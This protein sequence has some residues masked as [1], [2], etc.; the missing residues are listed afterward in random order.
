MGAPVDRRPSEF[1]DVVEPADFP[2]VPRD[3][4]AV[5][6]EFARGGLGRILRADDL[7]L[8]RTV[9]IKELLSKDA[10]AQARFIREAKITARLEHPNI[11]PIHEAGHWPD[12]PRFYAMK[13]VLGMTLATRLEEAVTDEERLQLVPHLIGVADAVAYA[14]SQG[15]LHRDLKPSNVMVGRFGE[16]VLIDWGLAKDLNDAESEPPSSDDRM[17]PGVFETSDGIVVGTPPY[18]PPEQAMAKRLDQRADVYSLGAMLYHVLSGHRPYHDTHPREILSRVVREPPVPLEEL[19]YD[20]PPDL[21]AIVNKAMARRPAD[22]YRSAEEMAAELRR[23]TA[24]R[25]VRAHSY[26]SWELLSRF[27]RRN[28]AS[29][30]VALMAAFGLMML[31]WWSYVQIGEERD[32]ARRN[33]KLAQ[34]ELEKFTLEK[35][36]VLLASDPTEALAWLKRLRPRT[37]QAATV[38]AEADDLGV[39]RLVLK[40]HSAVVNQVAITA[41]GRWGASVSDDRTVRLWDLA[42]GKSTALKAHTEK[43]TQ[44]VFSPDGQWLA[45]GSHDRTVRLWSLAERAKTRA[46]DGSSVGKSLDAQRAERA[47]MGRPAWPD[48]SP[49]SKSLDAQRAERA[50]MGRPAWPDGAPRSKSLD[51]QRAERAQMGRPAWP[52]GSPRSKSLDAQRAE[53]AQMGRPAWPDGAPLIGA[54]GPIKAIAFDQQGARVAAACE[55]GRVLVWSVDGTRLHVFPADGTGRYPDLA[56]VPAPDGSPS[57]WLAVGGFGPEVR[58]WSLDRVGLSAPAYRRLLGPTGRTAGLAVS[59]DGRSVA[60]GM[61]DGPVYVW[62]TEP[63]ESEPRVLPGPDDRR[64]RTLAFSPDGARL[65]AAGLDRRVRVWDLQSGQVRLL[66]GHEERVSDLAF[67]PSGAA[68]LSASWDGTVRMWMNLD[69]GGTTAD[70]LVFRGHADAVTGLAIS[71][72]GRHLLSGSWDQTLRLWEVS[73]QRQRVL[74]GHT[75]GVHGLAFGPQGRRLYSGGHDDQVRAWALDTRQSMVLGDHEDHIFRVQVSPDGRWVASSS[76]DRTVRLWNVETGDHRALRG[77]DA[78]VEEIAFSADSRWVVS[79]G[80]DNMAWLWSVPSGD[81]LRLSGHEND[82]TDVAFDPE[83]QRLATSSRDG[84]VRVWRTDGGVEHIFRD[85]T[86][87]VWSVAFSPNGQEVAAASADGR[88]RIWSIDSGAL[89]KTYQDLGEARRARFSPDGAFI[90]VTTSGRNLYLC[91]RAFD[92]C[93]RLVGHAAM[94]HDLTFSPDGH[95]LVTGASDNSVRV[96]DVETNES[97]VYRGHAAPVFDVDVSPDGRWIASGSADADIRVWPLRLPPKPDRL[98]AWLVDR[99]RKTVE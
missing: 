70:A 87:E 6:E 36:R 84:S 19:T 42:K 88:L 62:A 56:F 50:Q 91:R 13:L 99:T 45:T 78:D 79:A 10:R 54:A 90:A 98:R 61:A 11:V 39:A 17:S 20:L 55:D 93:D 52:D 2:V 38:A 3:N 44:V 67:A 32:I 51:A 68:I 82:V 26:S 66:V 57:K 58:L 59:A 9:A 46:T 8:G 85:A 97:R 89:V 15:I 64:W 21:V 43:V 65:A 73:P 74:R 75:V 30:T 40:G 31:G 35:A 41:D 24:G 69:V 76:D 14:H 94:V 33:M 72:D 77:H 28:L 29:L 80:E 86:D 53:R 22:R 83:S 48:G 47:Q 81:G 25:L 96:F 18:M 27:V 60:A 95:A 16:T 4:Y 37:R 5:G 92:F 34:A 63:T 1:A 23:F 49:R 7:R 71:R 12:G